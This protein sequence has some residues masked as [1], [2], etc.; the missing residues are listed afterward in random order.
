MLDQLAGH[1]VA[2][3]GHGVDVCAGV[4]VQAVGLVDELRD[5]DVALH[6]VAL[7][8]EAGPDQ[9]F[10]VRARLRPLG[11]QEPLLFEMKVILPSATLMSPAPM[12]RPAVISP[13]ESR[14]G[15]FRRLSA[16]SSLASAALSD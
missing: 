1:D 8:D 16:P 10:S 11:C 14:V 5:G 12:T 7:L 6:D 4:D 13:C 3:Q 15:Y 2:E 9:D